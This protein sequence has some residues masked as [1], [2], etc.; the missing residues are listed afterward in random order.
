MRLRLSY[1]F[2]LTYVRFSTLFRMLIQ[3]SLIVDLGSNFNNFRLGFTRRKC[4]L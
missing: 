3:K 2:D 4:N 1:N